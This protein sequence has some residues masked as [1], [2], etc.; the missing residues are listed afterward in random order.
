M[1][2]TLNSMQ[3][4]TKQ[5]LSSTLIRSC[6]LCD[7]HIGVREVHLK[8][9]WS[10]QSAIGSSSSKSTTV[11]YRSS[12][13][14]MCWQLQRACSSPIIWCLLLL[15]GGEIQQN[16]NSG[17]GT[18]SYCL[19]KLVA[20]SP[21]TTIEIQVREEYPVKKLSSS[22]QIQVYSF[23]VSCAFQKATGE[24]SKCHGQ[25]NLESN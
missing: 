20:S 4:L 10:M 23:A 25:L 17:K 14:S 1:N 13:R 7:R 15:F 19:S 2:W 6:E 18:H 8:S 3:M 22:N 11:Q 21:R 9:H 16:I 5:K 24:D 12:A